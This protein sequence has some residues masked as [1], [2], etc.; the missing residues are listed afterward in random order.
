M[1]IHMCDVCVFWLVGWWWGVSMF[2]VTTVPLLSKFRKH[3][4]AGFQINIQI[5]Q[6]ISQ[7]FIWWQHL[8]IKKGTSHCSNPQDLL[9]VIHFIY[10]LLNWLKWGRVNLL[11]VSVDNASSRVDR[12][13]MF[14]GVLLDLVCK[15]SCDAVL[16]AVPSTDTAF[17]WP[18]SRNKRF[19]T[20]VLGHYEE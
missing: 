7:R 20:H 4:Q 13:V 16:S 3:V 12:P 19:K 11:F 2:W 17:T 18:S 15:S 14:C 5:R 8:K 1:C 9:V 10:N 6:T